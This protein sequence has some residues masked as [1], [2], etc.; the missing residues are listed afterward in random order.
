MF[1]SILLVRIATGMRRVALIRNRR[2]DQ[3][4]VEAIA[5]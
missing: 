2:L 3:G 4:G 5:R 1:S